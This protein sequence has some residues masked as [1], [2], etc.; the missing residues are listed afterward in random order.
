MRAV[1]LRQVKST[2]NWVMSLG[3]CSGGACVSIDSDAGWGLMSVGGACFPGCSAY[4]G[5][6]GGSVLRDDILGV[7]FGNVERNN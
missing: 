6:G 1:K 3:I 5:G 2:S 4:A 7:R